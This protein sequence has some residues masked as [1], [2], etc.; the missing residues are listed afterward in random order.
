M[1]YINDWMMLSLAF[2][3]IC[4][5]GVLGR[6]L[7]TV[8]SAWLA[9]LLWLAFRFTDRLW[10]DTVAEMRDG[11]PRLD[12]A[13]WVP[14]SYGLLFAGFLLPFLIW[15]LY[16][17][18]QTRAITL[19]GSFTEILGPIG[20]LAAG[21]ILLCASMQAQ[22]LQ[23]DVEKRAPEMTRIARP[24]LTSL[25][26]RHVAPART[27]PRPAPAANASTGEAPR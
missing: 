25:G 24:L 22:L 7:G 15:F 17:K 20:G 4:G 19:P 14:A 18:R 1:N 8:A 13:F 2:A 21:F 23:A 10:R 3:L 16:S 6:L 26:Q 11:D 5:G 12:F 27:V 9:G